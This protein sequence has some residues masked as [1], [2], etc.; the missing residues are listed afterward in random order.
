[1]SNIDNLIYKYSQLEKRVNYEKVYKKFQ[2]EN[3]NRD[4][5]NE[6]IHIGQLKLF[7]TEML[8]LSKKADPKNKSLK[9]L[10]VGA[11]NG[12]HIAK[13]ADYFPDITFDLWDASEFEVARRPNIRIFNKFFTDEDALKYKKEAD[14]LL[15]NSDIRNLEIGK[16][17][18][19]ENIKENDK[20]IL[21]DLEKQVKWIQIIRPISSCIKFR[22]PFE[23][24]KTKTLTGKIYLQPFGPLGTE[25]RLITNDYDTKVE[26]DNKEVDEKLAYFNFYIRLAPNKNIR[27]KKIMDKYRIRNTWD[28]CVG[29]YIVQLYLKKIKNIESDEETGK[30]YMEI[31]E[32]HRK[33]FPMKINT[34][35]Y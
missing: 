34:L 4:K 35:F 11:A 28:N 20:I 16:Y 6:T 2:E 9:L 32:F 1:M 24:E 30:V 18:T 22:L 10:Y 33:R 14:N 19:Q 8:F 27:W 23:I 25:M 17:K 12:Y 3:K 15:F 5:L 21:K 31:L 29:L 13:L 26:Y 7:L